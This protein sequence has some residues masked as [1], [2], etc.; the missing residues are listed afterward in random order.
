M[1]KKIQ[2]LNDGYVNCYKRKAKETDF[3]ASV[4]AKKMEDLEFLV[5]LAFS[6]ETRREQDY[7]FAEAKS[8][9]LN[10]KIKTLLYQ[11]INSD[12][13]I[14]IGDTMYNII[15]LDP[16]KKNNVMYFYLEENRKIAQ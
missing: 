4:T 10:L 5:S 2:R 9:S 6:E 3:A 8:R 15:K 13:I 14:I 7:E 12:C 16:D 11:H 1:K